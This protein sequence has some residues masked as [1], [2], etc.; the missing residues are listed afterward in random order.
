MNNQLFLA[1]RGKALEK[2][3]SSLWKWIGCFSAMDISGLDFWEVQ[4]PYF[5]QT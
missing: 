5:P 1:L 4:F 2:K 3:A